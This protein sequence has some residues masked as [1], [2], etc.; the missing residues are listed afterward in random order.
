MRAEQ[1]VSVTRAQQLL[2]AIVAVCAVASVLGI[3]ADDDE[4]L[5]L[6]VARA[7]EEVVVMSGAGRRQPLRP[8]QP[9][10]RARLAVVLREDDRARLLLG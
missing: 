1:P 10:D 9:V 7:P 4:H 8:S 5:G 6:H 3:A 2:A